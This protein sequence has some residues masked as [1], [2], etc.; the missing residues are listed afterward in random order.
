MWSCRS[1]PWQLLWWAASLGA[2]RG[3]TG[4]HQSSL[5]RVLP[6]LRPGTF[7]SSCTSYGLFTSCGL[8][9]PLLLFFHLSWS[10]FHPLKS[11]PSSLFW[12]RLLQSL[13]FHLLSSSF[14]SYDLLWWF[15]HLVWSSLMVFSPLV[16]FLHL[17]CSLRLICLVYVWQLWSTWRD[18]LSGLASLWILCSKQHTEQTQADCGQV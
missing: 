18:L 3:G 8:L 11:L 6:P 9:S 17:L 1:A 4:D 10:C 7:S 16:V 2:Y 15:F 12:Y 13:F 14:T 5:W